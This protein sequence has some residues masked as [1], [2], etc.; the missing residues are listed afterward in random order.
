MIS[1]LTS[2]LRFMDTR[3]NVYFIMIMYLLIN[4]T[5]IYSL[6]VKNL[7]FFIKIY[8]NPHLQGHSKHICILITSS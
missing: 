1:E 2:L 4:T 8:V 6:K 5:K 7:K 3:D